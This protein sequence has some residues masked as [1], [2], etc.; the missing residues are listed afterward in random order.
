MDNS[1]H[2]Q[3]ATTQ[4]TCPMDKSPHEVL[5][6][7]YS[8]SSDKPEAAVI[9][10][11]KCPRGESAMELWNVMSELSWGEMYMLQVAIRRAV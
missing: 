9:H 10:G 3:L 8:Y 1:P 2:G 4:T 11:A 6:Y 5:E 7:M